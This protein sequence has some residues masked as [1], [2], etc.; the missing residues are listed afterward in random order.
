MK[1]DIVAHVFLHSSR[2]RVPIFPPLTTLHTSL[3]D[4]FPPP[5]FFFSHYF[6]L[7]LRLSPHPLTTFTLLPPRWHRVK[8]SPLLRIRLEGRGGSVLSPFPA[9]PPQQM[10]DEG[11][12][13]CVRSAGAVGCSRRS[14]NRRRES[15]VPWVATRR[16]VH[17]AAR[18]V[19]AWKGRGDPKKKGTA[20]RFECCCHFFEFWTLLLFTPTFLLFLL[21][22]SRLLVLDTRERER[23]PSIWGG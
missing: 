15:T 17:V 13:R 3:A 2:S 9:P 22:F 6:L 11:R 7:P 16:V 8:L 20:T 4:P 18:L 12:S 19:P 1:R 5:F 23:A 10:A 14:S 21:L